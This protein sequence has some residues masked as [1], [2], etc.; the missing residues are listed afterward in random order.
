MHSK[1]SMEFSRASSSC[2][3]IGLSSVLISHACLLGLCITSMGY[4]VSFYPMPAYWGCA[5]PASLNIARVSSQSSVKNLSPRS[6]SNSLTSRKNLRDGI[7]IT[8]AN[9]Q[10][11]K[12]YSENGVLIPKT[13]RIDDP[14]EAAKSSIW[15]TL[16]I[17]NEKASSLYGCVGLFKAIPSKGNNQNHHHMVEVLPVLQV[18]PATLSRSVAFHEQQA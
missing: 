12:P 2:I 14:T 18:N 16:G 6:S 1:F 9:S 15:S 11:E 17:K 8:Q 3:I 7:I 4:P 13:L 5:L 10:K